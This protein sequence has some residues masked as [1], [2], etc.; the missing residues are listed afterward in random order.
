[1]A[2]STALPPGSKLPGLLQATLLLRDP[3]GYLESCRRRFGSVFRFKLPGA[4]PVAYIADPGIARELYR[5]DAEGN[6]A[7]D[8][9][10][11]Y[12]APLVGEHSLLCVE[13]EEWDR[14]RRLLAPPLHGQ[15]VGGWRDEIAA[16]AAAEI[17]TWPEGEEIE[18]RPRMQRITL[19]VIL[20][21]VFGIEDA[22]RLDRLRRV[23]PDLLEAVDSIVFGLPDVRERLERSRVLRRLPGN[24]VR[25]FEA[26][27][28]EADELVYEEIARVRQLPE[29]ALAERTDV[30]STLLAARDED[31]RPMEDSELRDELI[32]LLTAGHETTA[33]AL[34]WAFERLVR[35]PR[36]LERL[37]EE[38]DGGDGGEYLEA[39]IKE[40]LRS[41][42]VVFDTPRVLGEPV[43][44]GEYT[45]PAGWWAAPA[46]PLVQRAPEMF[47]EPDDFQPERFLGDDTPVAGWIPFGGGKR[48]C[49][50]SRLA[51]L[52]LET[53]IPAVL[54]RRTLS[55]PDPAPEDQRVQHVTLAPAQRTRVLTRARG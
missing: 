18:L 46:I 2:T 24:P 34:A 49:L 26:I 50:G 36:V 53:V 54:T 47:A 30:L 19:E 32:T 16:L 33:T 6:R 23:L 11:P 5:H 22:G 13:G 43:Q 7:G 12:L 45:V 4:P 10:R 1:M 21:L 37:L 29:A 15:R 25:R 31:G 8:A 44:L 9:R 39:V 42:P 52:E 35:H 51:L 55:A 17:D 48:R 28:A 38:I 41:R 40:V 27:R 3:V 14:Q 20:R